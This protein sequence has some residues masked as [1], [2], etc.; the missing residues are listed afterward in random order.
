MISTL[1]LI[2][3]GLLRQFHQSL[4]LG[5]LR[6]VT[7]HH[8]NTAFRLAYDLTLPEGAWGVKEFLG[9][10]LGVILATAF[11]VDEVDAESHSLSKSQPVLCKN[12]GKLLMQSLGKF[13][14]SR[15]G[16]NL[17]RFRFLLLIG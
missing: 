10:A 14:S 15:N 2:V 12:F 16:C 3:S 17:N 4:H 9:G 13:S 7:L 5:G 1:F 6:E 8:W 11:S